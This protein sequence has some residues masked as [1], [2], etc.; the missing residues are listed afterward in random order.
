MNI[1]ILTPILE[2]SFSNKKKHTVKV[3]DEVTLDVTAA[4]AGSPVRSATLSSATSSLAFTFR[5]DP[6]LEVILEPNAD[7]SEPLLR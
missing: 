6:I 4:K 7:L 2:Q 1:P 5:V 3:D